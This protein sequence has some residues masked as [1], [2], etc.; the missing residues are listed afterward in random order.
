MLITV[1]WSPFG[2]MDELYICR[3]LRTSFCG[4]VELV[5][6]MLWLPKEHKKKSGKTKIVHFVRNP[7]DMVLSNYF[8]HSQDPTVSDLCVLLLL[9][10]FV[11]S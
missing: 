6:R 11:Q 7:F 4:D 5:E 8:Y 9:Y 2:C 3:K 10:A 1:P